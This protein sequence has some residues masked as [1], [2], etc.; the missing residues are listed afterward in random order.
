IAGV[1]ADDELHSRRHGDRR[2]APGRQV[3]IALRDLVALQE[4]HGDHPTG[5]SPP[6]LGAAAP[7][8][9][10]PAGVAAPPRFAA[11]RDMNPSMTSAPAYPD[12]MMPSAN[13]A[14]IVLGL[15]S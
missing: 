11:W 13:L 4:R 3:E 15:P 6:A 7:P 14:S 9:P 2:P 10:P 8:P 5:G 12:A 1:V